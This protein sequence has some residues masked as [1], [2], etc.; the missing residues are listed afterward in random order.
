MTV[1]LVG[2]RLGPTKYQIKKI[3]IL[4][5]TWTG[6]R[7]IMEEW[8]CSRGPSMKTLL[9]SDSLISAVKVQLS[10]VLNHHWFTCQYVAAASHRRRAGAAHLYL[11][12]QTYRRKMNPQRLRS[13]NQRFLN[14]DYSKKSGSWI[15]LA[16]PFP[17]PI[18]FLCNK[19]DPKRIKACD[20]L[21]LYTQRSINW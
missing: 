14:P 6:Q 3:Y 11:T 8:A 21:R 4:G 16:N 9:L 5:K 18:W 15:I 19:K 13:I 10:T 17:N 20:K 12:R 1:P 7:C 2:H